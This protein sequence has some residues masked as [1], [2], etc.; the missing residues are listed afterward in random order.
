[1][2]NHNVQ[3]VGRLIDVHIVQLMGE[4]EDLC[5]DTKDAHTLSDPQL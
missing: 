2:S 3:S 1:M 5:Y 4:S